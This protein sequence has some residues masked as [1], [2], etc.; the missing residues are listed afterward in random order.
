MAI[1]CLHT[2]RHHGVRVPE[3]LSLV[4]F[5]NILVAEFLSPP[6]TTVDL[7]MRDIGINGMR[8]LHDLLRETDRR[9][10]IRTHETMLIVRQS[11][12]P[13]R[14]VYAGFAAV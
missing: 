9:K 5:D 6:L 10:T 12:A 14:G 7:H 3:E 1:G 8:R 2:L 13:P 11:S 4:G